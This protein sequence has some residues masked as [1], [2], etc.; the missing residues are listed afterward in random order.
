[1]LLA[2]ATACSS[3]STPTPDPGVPVLS[4]PADQR[5]VSATNLPTTVVYPKP[6]LT[7][8]TAPVDSSCTPVQGTTFAL[9]ATR[10]S[11]TTTD[12]RQQTSSCSF[13]VNVLPG[14]TLAAARVLAFGDSITEG[15][16]NSLT[17]ATLADTCPAD[18]TA[19]PWTYPRV[20]A[21]S[22]GVQYPSQT[23][24]VTDCGIGGEQA[25]QGVSR[26]PIALTLA[27]YDVVLLMEGANDLNEEGVTGGSRQT[28][29]DRVSTALVSMIRSA[30]SGRTVF[31]GTLVP[32]RLG[33]KAAR[34]DWVE[35]VNNRL[36]TVVP[37]EGAVLVDLYQAFGGSPDPL[38]GPD[39]L[40]P[41]AAGYQRIA[42]TFLAAIR[43]TLE[44]K[45]PALTVAAPVD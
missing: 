9:G 20:L 44:R 38:I 16:I 34:P 33:G 22:L 23:V 4:C 18:A 19:A 36:R 27:T 13:F 21:S 41:T 40:H 15:K 10:V 1:M 39:G 24:P 32:Q 2:F 12:A 42:E 26:L 37:A 31:V 43:T 28:A 25:T 35:P 5:I 45:T 11:C 6:T 8:G 3:P 29:I 7:G 14:T 17:A 30:R